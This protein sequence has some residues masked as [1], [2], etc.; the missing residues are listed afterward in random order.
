MISPAARDSDPVPS[1]WF[2][3]GWALLAGVV[4]FALGVFHNDFP[5]EYHPDEPS[6]VAQLL[7]GTRNY[8][9]P[10]LMLTLADAAA[11]VGGVAREPARPRARGPH[12][13]GGVPGRGGGAAGRA[14]RDL[15]GHARVAS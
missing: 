3:A 4:M 12:A 5:C 2:V 6:K 13:L 10:P 8:H 7:D 11:R 1:R 14:G 9:H 15:R